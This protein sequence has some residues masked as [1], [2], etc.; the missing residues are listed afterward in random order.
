MVSSIGYA[1]GAG[2]GIDTAK[3]IED[4]YAA[5]RAPKEAAIK[6]R[7]EANAA[8]ISALGQ[9]SNALASFSTALN[10][11]ISTGTL[12][13]QPVIS[14]SSILSA[15]ALTG[16]KIGDYSAQLEVKQLAKAQSLVSAQLSGANAAV[17]E[18]TLT[19]SVSGKDYDI[20]ITSANNSL[21]GLVKAIN[22]ART[23]VSASIVTENGGAKLMLKGATGEAQAFSLSVPDGTD[24][25]LERFAFGPGV[26]GGLTEAQA[27]RDAIIILD[28]VEI[29]R[30]SNTVSDVISG[31]EL[32]LK[33]EVPGTSISMTT[34]RPREAI[35]QAMDDFVAAFNELHALLNELTT[36]GVA[37]G[38]AGPLRDDI[39][40]R[41][42]KRQLNALT[43]TVLGSNAQGPRTLSEIGAIT[44]RDGTLSV[45]PAKLS[46]ALDRFPDAVEALFNPSQHSSNPNIVIT[47]VIGKV[48]PGTYV[49]TNAK[50]GVNGG[51]SS[52]V[53]DGNAVNGAGDYVIAPYN[54]SAVGLSFMVKGDVAEAT[55]TIDPG[56][57]GAL[58][59]IRDALFANEGPLASSNS[60]LQQNA[61]EIAED[62][63]KMDARMTAYRDQLVT[64]Y[65]A[66]EKRVSAFKATQTYLDQQ[67][68]MWT[69]SN[70]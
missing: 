25:G 14:D 43:S 7:E 69:K 44:N 38:A 64:S 13:T 48:K 56:L 12:S 42:V 33:R 53:I 1:L 32:V 11:L 54:S 24:S 4:L 55:I 58:K 51:N 34:E 9:A 30:A 67:I 57:G 19:L 41:D 49:I 20:E 16:A 21:D 66:M 15:K 28:G 68:K 60:R 6:R 62:R 5:S 8:K 46:D 37:G 59:S 47:S 45:A 35:T 23:G 39:G 63:E 52:A 18:G 70:D 29:R 61:K 27:A 10:A 2:S 65:A 31:V 36:N 26:T 40:I 22:D 17:G 50:A 3:L